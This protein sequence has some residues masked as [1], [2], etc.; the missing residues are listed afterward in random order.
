MQCQVGSDIFTT[1]L[2]TPC[3]FFCRCFL[4]WTLHARGHILYVTRHEPWQGETC[5]ASCICSHT[6]RATKD[7]KKAE[8]ALAE[9]RGRAEA[10][11]EGLKAAAEAAEQRT[12]QVQAALGR[13]ESELTSYQGARARAAEGQGRGAGEG[14]RGGARRAGGRP[15]ARAGRGRRR[16]H[17]AQAGPCSCWN[18][19]PA[20]DVRRT[21]A[22]SEGVLKRSTF[23]E[24]P[25]LR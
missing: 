23:L 12:A 11:K 19:A 2:K 18:A 4:P 14:A 13:A 8:N 22:Y 3:M 21:L 7:T 17:R 6:C 9:L 1:C 10:E 16:H 15:G 5:S 25:G 20:P 24:G